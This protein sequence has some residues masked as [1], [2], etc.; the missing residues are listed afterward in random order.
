MTPRFPSLLLATAML[1][2]A[3]AE[4]PTGPG[5]KDVLKDPSILQDADKAQKALEKAIADAAKASDAEVEAAVVDYLFKITSS[6]KA[7]AEQKIL[8]S[9]E[10][11]VQPVV[12]KHLAEKDRYAVFV[13]PTGKTLLPEAPFHRA[14]DI[15]GDRPPDAA[16]PL[17]APFLNDPDESIRQ[18]AAL[19]IA[20]TGSPEIVPHIRKALADPEEYVRSYAL[21]GLDWAAGKNKS[22]RPGVAKELYPDVKRLVE[23]GQNGDKAPE[24]LVAF[25]PAAAKEFFLSPGFFRADSDILHQALNALGNASI[26]VPAERLE[27]LIAELRAA[28]LKYPRDYLLSQALRL[29]A[30][31]RRPADLELFKGLSKHP[32]EDVAEG[33]SAA[34]VTWYGLEGFGERLSKLEQAKGYAAL[35]RPQQHYSAVFMF[36]AEVCN[37]GLDQ[38]F[39]NSTGNQWKDALEGLKAMKDTKRTAIL[40][41]AAAKFGTDGPST[42][43]TKRQ[44]QLAAL[45]RKDEDTFSKLDDEYYDITP[46]IE[47]VMN[48]YVLANPEAFK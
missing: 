28:E 34:L 18:E 8:H 46:P 31:H 41:K 24:I 4:E 12:M 11:R 29:L 43:R 35:N 47:A 3:Y 16:V 39:L 23:K 17:L 32:N 1:G 21:M 33:A 27:P 42:D 20:K 44:D 37:G 9:L 38:Y 48:A 40:E 13:K 15:L 30:R 36:D 2:V 10:K 26:E 5:F 19:A 45:I 14:C 22:L 7:W 25:D 6:D